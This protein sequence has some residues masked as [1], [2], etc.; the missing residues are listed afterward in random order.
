M[1]GTRSSRSGQLTPPAGD[2]EYDLQQ[3]ARYNAG[4]AGYTQQQLRGG[5]AS[6]DY[7]YHV[8]ETIEPGVDYVS[9]SSASGGV[10]VLGS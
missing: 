7:S 6:S 9:I 8:P 10:L 1:S 4:D 2:I 3:V 5:Q